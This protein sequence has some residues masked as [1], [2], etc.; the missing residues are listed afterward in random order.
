MKALL[1]E[2][3]LAIAKTHNLASLFDELLPL[4][5]ALKGQR[6]FL[7][8]LTKYAIEVRYPGKRTRKREAEACLCW[9][10]RARA[11]CRAFLGMK[12]P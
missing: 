6:R 1:N 12:V 11:T 8:A 3:G 10:G 5:P 2:F 4:V 7:R 9:A